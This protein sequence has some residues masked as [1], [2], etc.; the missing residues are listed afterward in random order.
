MSLVRSAALQNFRSVVEQLGGD[1]ALYA[2]LADL[3][4]DALDSDDLLVDDRSVAAVL[5][6]ASLKL[7]CP[8]LGLRVGATQELGLLGML[9]VAI[10]N[11]PSV[12][13]ALES[14]A[15]YMFVHG[16][17]LSLSVVDDPDRRAG[18]VALL[19]SCGPGA[20]PLPQAAEMTL[21]FIHRATAFLVGDAYAPRTVDLPHQPVAAVE[22]YEQ[23]F[24]SKV[25]FGREHT[26]L[27]VPARLLAQ[28]LVGSDQTLRRLA[29]E[30]L[31]A[32]S[33]DNRASVTDHVRLILQKTLSMGGAPLAQVARVM[34]LHPRTL[35]RQLA[36]EGETFASVVDAVRRVRARH[37]LTATD[38]PM[39]Q[40]SS[41]LGFSEQAVL[42]RSA[43]RWWGRTPT[44]LRREVREAGQ[45]APRHRDQRGGRGGAD[46]GHG[47]ARKPV[48]P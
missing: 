20:R 14:I 40:I 16:R 27:R 9:A 28:P 18:V 41:L 38:M 43:R 45:P 24:G 17:R 13:E 44:N 7:S 19:Y 26:A 4:L 42:S 10:Q 8:D 6:I 12:A 34:M 25:R 21:L 46:M 37:Y 15:R 23:A 39:S 32:R 47:F 3:P 30:Y 35:Q 5:E 48:V 22:V 1:A 36:E 29:L 11:A 31:S 2:G 33:H